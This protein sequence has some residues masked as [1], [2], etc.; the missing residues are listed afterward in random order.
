[1][2]TNHNIEIPTKEDKIEKEENQEV[3]EKTPAHPGNRY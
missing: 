3:K 2:S 1:M